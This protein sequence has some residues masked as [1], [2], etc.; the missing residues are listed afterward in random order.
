MMFNAAK[1]KVMPLSHRN[2]G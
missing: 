2:S 1:C